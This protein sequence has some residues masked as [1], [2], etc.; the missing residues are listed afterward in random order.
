MEEEFKQL[1]F[2][3]L[4]RIPK[5]PPQVRSTFFCVNWEDKLF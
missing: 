2:H 1:K 5:S 3:S 4:Q